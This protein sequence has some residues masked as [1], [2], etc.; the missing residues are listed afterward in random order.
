MDVAEARKTW[1]QTY[2]PHKVCSSVENWHVLMTDAEI[3]SCLL[4]LAAKLNKQFENNK[5]MCVVLLKGAFVF[6]SDFARAV[7][8]PCTFHFVRA[9]SYG[10]GASQT[11]QATDVTIQLAGDVTIDSEVDTILLLDELFDSGKTLASVA[12][13]YKETMGFS[14]DR[15]FT[16]TLFAKEHHSPFPAPTFAGISDLPELWLAGYGLDLDGYARGWPHLMVRITEDD[17]A[18]EEGATFEERQLA[19]LDA[20]RVTVRSRIQQISM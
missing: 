9:K 3:K 11:E 6:A 12:R 1:I 10:S 2:T 20:I 8:F 16:C 19:R 13:Y 4:D 15:I 7:N 18:K 14:K 17:C 5:V